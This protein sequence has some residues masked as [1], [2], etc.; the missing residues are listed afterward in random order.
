M[1][2]ILLALT[3]VTLMS[4]AMVSNSY[5]D[6][7][8]YLLSDCT[9]M[10]DPVACQESKLVPA[11]VVGSFFGLLTGGVAFAGAG[12]VIAA[13]ETSVILGTTIGLETALVGGAVVGGLAAAT[14][15]TQ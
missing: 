15:A 14:L 4:G 10:E 9:K 2:N 7:K 8:Y 13:G 12:G 6:E 11:L 1:K 3:A 5:A